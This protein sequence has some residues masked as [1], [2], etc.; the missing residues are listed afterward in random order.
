MLDQAF[1]FQN[2][3]KKFSLV[4]C[5]ENLE[6]KVN[7]LSFVDEQCE[8]I[9]A[10]VSPLDLIPFYWH[11][12]A[13]IDLHDDLLAVDFVRE[14]FEKHFPLFQ[15][16]DTV[17]LDIPEKHVKSQT[18]K[19]RDEPPETRNPDITEANNK[20]SNGCDP[21]LSFQNIFKRKV[22]VGL[23]VKLVVFGF[24]DHKDNS[25][26][27]CNNRVYFSKSFQTQIKTFIRMC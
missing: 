6:W 9:F 7:Q 20:G 23:F 14:F 22:D 13:R 3:R 19:S 1:V 8:V 27:G 16:R 25:N 18:Y 12:L 21:P 2:T 5:I 11:S 10:N 4:F 15:L 24:Y 26:S 17:K